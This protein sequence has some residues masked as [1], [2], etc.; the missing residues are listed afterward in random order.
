MA[1]TKIIGVDACVNART[2]RVQVETLGPGHLPRLI[3][4]SIV[5]GCFSFS[6]VPSA[7]RN[8]LLQ[9]PARFG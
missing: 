9:R 4:L 1:N 6:F 2:S 7:V 3:H 5:G 8:L